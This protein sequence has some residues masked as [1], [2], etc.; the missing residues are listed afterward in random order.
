MSCRLDGLG[1]DPW[2]DLS[3]GWV[4]VIPIT[5]TA[6]PNGS[7]KLDGLGQSDLALRSYFGSFGCDL[8][9]QVAPTWGMDLQ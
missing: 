7:A 8:L 3:L 1:L 4:P 2:L 6:R 5:L 9:A